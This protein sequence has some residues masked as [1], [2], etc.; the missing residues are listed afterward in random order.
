MPASLISK[1]IQDHLKVHGRRDYY[2]Y[3]II[4]QAERGQLLKIIV[5][6]DTSYFLLCGEINIDGYVCLRSVTVFAICGLI[7]IYVM[8]PF[9][10]YLVKKFDINKLLIVS[11]SVFSIFFIDNAYNFLLYKYFTIP[12][13]S[14]FYQ[15]KGI[16]YLYFSD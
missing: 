14:T 1:G 10:I 12:K 5:K 6:D 3:P 9:L 2:Q 8:L 7:L 15:S 11:I 13:A 16:K 4:F